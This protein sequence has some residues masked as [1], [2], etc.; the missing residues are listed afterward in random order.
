MSNE[1]ENQ[2][3]I[4]ARV[5]I[6]MLGAPKEHIESTL[7]KYI[8]SLKKDSKMEIVK[9]DL[10]PAKEQDKLFSAFAELD[11]RFA[12][13][14]KLI[15]FCFDSMPSSVEILEPEKIEID[16]AA[17][18]A[19]LNDMQAKLH[20]SEMVI[21][22]LK[23]KGILLDK[24][25]KSVLTNFIYFLIKD[26]PEDIGYLSE[27]MGITPNHLKPFLDDLIKKGKLS[28]KEDRYERVK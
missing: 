13:A 22:T 23:A 11:I 15:D 20:H 28:E 21:K 9:E 3:K 24:N 18:T 7:K 2:S 16:S 10:A 4:L 12:H 19:T 26:G 14:N 6:E 1:S 17:L 5:I 8:D 27:N 25:A